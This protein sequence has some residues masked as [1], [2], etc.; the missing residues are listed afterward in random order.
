MGLRK[1]KLG[2]KREAEVRSK[3]KNTRFLVFMGWML[4]FSGERKLY[5]LSWSRR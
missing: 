5:S 1:V 4:Q 2:R 3:L